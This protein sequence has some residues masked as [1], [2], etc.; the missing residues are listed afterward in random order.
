MNSPGVVLLVPLTF[1]ATLLWAPWFIGRLRQ[2]KLGKQIRLEGPSSHQ[3]KSGTPTMGGW[4]FILTPL[5]VCL[6]IFPDRA[7]VAPPLAGMLVYGIVG[8]LDD[9]ANTRSKVGLGF[10]VR[11]KLLWHG[12]IAL[13]LAWW[14]YQDPTLRVQRLPGGLA[15]D[16]GWLFIPFAALVVF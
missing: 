5:V 7:A 4:L 8:A 12:G 10:Q 15:L 1:L 14:L 11:Y 3:V 13:A 16:L 9:Y 6:V 2:L